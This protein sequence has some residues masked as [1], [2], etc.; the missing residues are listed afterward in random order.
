VPDPHSPRT[1]PTIDGERVTL[2]AALGTPNPTRALAM[3]REN[4]PWAKVGS[5]FRLASMT[6]RDATCWPSGRRYQLA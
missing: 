5:L 4:L 3:F 2:Y 1:L 6:G